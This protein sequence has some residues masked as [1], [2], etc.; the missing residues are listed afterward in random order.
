MAVQVFLGQPSARIKQWIIDHHP[1]PVEDPDP[2]DLTPWGQLVSALENCNPSDFTAMDYTGSDASLIN[3]KVGTGLTVKYDIA[4]DGNLVDTTWINLGF[5]A[6]IPEYI[7][8]RR[9]VGS[10][11]KH[12]WIKSM[13]SNLLAPIAI[14]DQVYVRSFDDESGMHTWTAVEGEVVTAI[15]GTFTYGNNTP[16]GIYSVPTSITTAKG[17]Y[18][19]CGYNMTLNSQALLRFG[20]GSMNNDVFTMLY[21]DSNGGYNRYATT[22]IRAILNSKTG[23]CPGWYYDT[24]WTVEGDFTANSVVLKT[25]SDNGLLQNITNTV[26]RTW[27]HGS[28]RSAAILDENNCEHVVDK[29]W[30]LGSGNIANGGTDNLN[31]EDNKYD[32]TKFMQ[33]NSNASRI[34]YIMKT[35]GSVGGS[36]DD[37]WLRS[38]A[39]SS[40]NYVGYASWNGTMDYHS[41]ISY[42]GCSPA[43][44]IG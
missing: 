42:R 22:Q 21:F 44:Q 23:T 34:K 38:A 32:S 6:S 35:N 25:T 5:N 29:F 17:T 4:S 28:L 31:G 37:W 26:N 16:Y 24:D 30:L 41:A 27:V 19:F 11:W 3:K 8:Y 33:F 10:G 14:G 40:D 39:S 15:D 1:K 13:K 36:E 12:I 7:K 18:A 20:E 9:A 2:V 43:F